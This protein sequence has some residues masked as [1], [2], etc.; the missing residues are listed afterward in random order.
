M[1]T[2]RPQG[3]QLLRDGGH[4]E[5]GD[6][7]DLSEGAAVEDPDPR[8]RAQDRARDCADRVRVAAQIRGIQE[9]A[10]GGSRASSA[11]AMG[12]ACA[13][14]TEEPICSANDSGDGDGGVDASSSARRVAATTSGSGTH[15]PRSGSEST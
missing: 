3:Q 1:L 13:E 12:I 7:L 14:A 5:A 9:G 4:A 2:G 10:R 8:R 6:L 11:K 15:A